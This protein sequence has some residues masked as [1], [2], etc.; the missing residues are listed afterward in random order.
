MRINATRLVAFHMSQLHNLRT[1][2]VPFLPKI[3]K[4]NASFSFPISLTKNESRRIEIQIQKT[5][6]NLWNEMSTQIRYLN[7]S[8][9]NLTESN[10]FH[11]VK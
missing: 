6:E 1:V 9:G 7:I 4:L 11:G 10:F 2:K 5:A 3:R 8:Y